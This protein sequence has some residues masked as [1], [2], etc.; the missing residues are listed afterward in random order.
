ME[1]TAEQRLQAQ[2]ETLINTDS[3]GFAAFV[4]KTAS[5]PEVEV[6][7]STT[8]TTM[9]VA[10]LMADGVEDH[11]EETVK[12]AS[13]NPFDHP[14]E[15]ILSATTHFLRKV[16]EEGLD[17]PTDT[18]R[19][20]EKE[21]GVRT[22]AIEGLGTSSARSLARAIEDHS[23]SSKGRGKYNPIRRFQVWRAGRRGAAKARKFAKGVKMVGAAARQLDDIQN[24][25]QTPQPSIHPGQY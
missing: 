17:L 19:L 4:E 22:D 15:L 6:E 20:L 5:A 11:N 23:Q 21:A 9:D 3:V 12:E 18:F 13:F 24:G 25:T 10:E 7:H 1:K 2:L 8:G 14:E 16:A